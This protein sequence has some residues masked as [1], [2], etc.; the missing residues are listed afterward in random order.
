MG[1]LSTNVSSWHNE[2]WLDNFQHQC[3][4]LKNRWT[5]EGDHGLLNYAVSVSSATPIFLSSRNAT[6]LPPNNS[7][8]VERILERLTL[9]ERKSFFLRIDDVVVIDSVLEWVLLDCVARGVPA[10]LE[11]IPY[12]S[13]LRDDVLDKWD[14]LRILQVSQH[15]YAH[16]P[17]VSKEGT[18]GEYIAESEPIRQWVLEDLK[19]GYVK[20]SQH[21]PRRFQRGFSPP[22]DGLAQWLPDHW[23]NCGGKYL[24]IMNPHFRIECP[25]VT[26]AVDLWNWSA[27]KPRPL[28][29][30]MIQVESEISKRG[31]AGIVLH[32]QLLVEPSAREIYLQALDALA[33]AGIN[34]RTATS[35]LKGMDD[36]EFTVGMGMIPAIAS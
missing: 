13:S 2:S 5:G 28:E 32:P 25:T 15:G 9:T 7:K 21:F 17:S 3:N 34:A 23:R 12:L 4:S 20:L 14:P 10:S 18:V 19:K 1:L 35:L 31:Y 30:V 36:S 24:S 26:C 11:V 29:A 27:C 8:V 16:L 33:T 6:A 22:Y